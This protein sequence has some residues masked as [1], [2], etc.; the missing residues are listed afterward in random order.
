M[1]TMPSITHVGVCAQGPAVLPLIVVLYKLY[2]KIG[3]MRL[4]KE[5]STLIK[6]RYHPKSYPLGEQVPF[7][8]FNGV[9]KVCS[10]SACMCMHVAMH[11]HY[12]W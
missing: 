4:S 1:Y 8:F 2:F 12:K 3:N 6:D 5:L 10:S 11:V 7:L 9:L